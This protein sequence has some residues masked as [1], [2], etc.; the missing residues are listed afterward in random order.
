MLFEVQS[1]GSDIGQKTGSSSF[2]LSDTKLRANPCRT[3]LHKYLAC[4]KICY[5]LRYI[6]NLF[7]HTY[8]DGVPVDV[9]GTGVK[10]HFISNK[11][12]Q[13]TSDVDPNPEV[14]NKGKGRV[15][16][17]FFFVFQV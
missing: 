7:Q 17:Q 1:P 4:N 16:Q 3:M 6:E 9:N 13:I 14:S 10:K 8:W 2:S 11:N 12:I 15:K 5:M